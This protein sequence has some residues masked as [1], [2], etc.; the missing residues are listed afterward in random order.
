MDNRDL[1]ISMIGI[2]IKLDIL[3]FNCDRTV[4]NLAHNNIWLHKALSVSQ[5]PNEYKC[6]KSD[7][8]IIC[9]LLLKKVDIWD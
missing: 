7:F 4:Q 1:F 2:G 8:A 5:G 9:N 6:C 3:Q